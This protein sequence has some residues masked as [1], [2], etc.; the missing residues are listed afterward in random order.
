MD[1]VVRLYV[2]YSIPLG[3]YFALILEKK[4]GVSGG[5][6]CPI[7]ET[8]RDLQRHCAV[9]PADLVAALRAFSM[10]ISPRALL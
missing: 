7:Q 3:I 10:V 6:F 9:P 4:R 1:N 2:Y 8:P 5:S